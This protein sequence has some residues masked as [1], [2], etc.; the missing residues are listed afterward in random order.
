MATKKNVKKGTVMQKGD[1]KITLTHPVQV[2][3]F[4]NSG[5]VDLEEK[6]AE[7]SNEG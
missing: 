3:A 6:V 5:W 2:A 7:P 1:K 4:K